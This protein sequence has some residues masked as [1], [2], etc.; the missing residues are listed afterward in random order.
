MLWKTHVA[1]G[2]LS[3]LAVLPFLMPANLF[4]FFSVVILSS[5]L[6]DIDHTK[7]KISSKIPIIP[8]II[9]LFFKHRGIIHSLPFMALVAYIVNIFLGRELAI[10]FLVGFLSHL[11]ADGLTISGINFLHPFA[12]LRLQG[13]VETGSITE[14]FFFILLIFIMAIV[15]F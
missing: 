13:F 11:I 14:T 9:Q 15:L 6:P 12:Q 7:S 2:I 10:A 1:F 8:S 5:I 4:L 3:A